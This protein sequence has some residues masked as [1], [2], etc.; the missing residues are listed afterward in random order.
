[1]AWLFERSGPGWSGTQ[2]LPETEGGGGERFGSAVALSADGETALVGAPGEAGK[3]GAVWVFGPAARVEMLGPAP[4]VEAVSPSEGPA[5]GDTAVTIT[6]TNLGEA[7]AVNF[8][9]AEAASFAVS[10]PTT[11]TAVSPPGSGSVDVTVSSPSGTS[12][13]SS[14]DRFHYVLK[15][16]GSGERGGGNDGGNGAGGEASGEGVSGGVSAG[17]SGGPGIVGQGAQA[18]LASGP[19]TGGA[20]RVSLLS[21]KILVQAHN[22]AL[23]ELRTT[24][25]GRCGGKLR[26]KVDVRLT[27]KRYKA[28][29]IGS[30]VFFIAAGKTI[31]IKVNLNAAGRA[32]L[33]AAHGRLRASLLI[34]RSSP[35]PALASTA[36][37]RLTR[38]RAHKPTARKS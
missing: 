30:A 23:L 13:T 36:S 7:T 26:L 1:V 31:A 38:Q 5:A 9:S 18:V 20:C 21:R 3:A 10:S 28:H 19:T 25:S 2:L 8:G 29:T 27:K 22:R 37:V 17:G 35:A 24:G 32:L 14:G 15:G 6:G 11:I 16:K 4:S 12:A 33:K 34:V